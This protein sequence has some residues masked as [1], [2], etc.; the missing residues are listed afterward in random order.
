MAK[1]KAESA[2]VGGG[3]LVEEAAKLVLR[4]TRG[5]GLSVQVE[6]PVVLNRVAAL[7]HGTDELSGEAA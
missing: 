1:K 7:L 4:T 3:S 5:Q 2:F 6:D